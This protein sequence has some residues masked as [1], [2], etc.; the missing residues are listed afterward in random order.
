MPEPTMT[1][2]PAGVSFFGKDFPAY[3][4]DVDTHMQAF[5]GEEFFRLLG[6]K[7]SW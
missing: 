1:P 7:E 4:P 3:G 5:L 6:E 2:T